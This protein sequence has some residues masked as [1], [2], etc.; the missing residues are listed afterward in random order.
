MTRNIRIIWVASVVFGL[1]IGAY[2]FVLPYYLKARGLDYAHM[3]TIFAISSLVMFFVRIYVGRLSDLFGRKRFYSL[4][5][6]GSGLANLLTP[7]AGSVTPLALLR[8][9]REASAVTRESIHALLLYKESRSRYAELLGKT[10]GSEYVFQGIG[11]LAAGVVMAYLGMGQALTACAILLMAVFLLFSIGFQERKEPDAPQP[12]PVSW[13]RLFSFDMPRELQ[14]LAVASFLLSVGVSCSHCFMM[15]LFFK[16][17]FLAPATL[18]AAILAV[19]RMVLGLPVLFAG[20]YT[21]YLRL[22]NSYAAF[23]SLQGIL[24]AVAGIIPSLWPTAI[25]WLLHDLLAGGFAFPIQSTMIQRYSDEATRGLHVSKAMAYS[26]LG[27]V[28]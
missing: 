14:I 12:P 15:P 5:L 9:L 28:L 16:E 24:I 2:D 18:V 11:T 17:K 7:V 23:V 3:G 26:A 4:A 19:H 13:I 27:W 25:L 22:R 20:R 10:F 8:S 6:L 1:A 21:P